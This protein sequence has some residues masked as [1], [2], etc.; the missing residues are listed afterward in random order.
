MKKI[1]LLGGIAI[2]AMFSTGCAVNR[3]TADVTPGIELSKDAAYYVVKPEA[4]ERATNEII[5]RQ[6]SELGYP[7]TTGPEGE[8]P[9]DTDTVVTYVDRWMW[10][11]TMYM[12]E[13]TLTMSDA[14]TDFTLASGNSFHTSMTRKS[15]EKMV[16]EVLGNIFA[17]EGE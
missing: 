11:I 6:L 10:D 5:A 15:P 1:I 3:A 4:D 8:I 16:A 13:L 14:K 17:G 9:E 2:L 12:I 7:A